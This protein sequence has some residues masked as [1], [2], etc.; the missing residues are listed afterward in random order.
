MAAR[1]SARRHLPRR[2]LRAPRAAPHL[3]RLRRPSRL[4]RAGARRARRARLAI[5]A[6]DVR[7]DAEAHPHELDRTLGR[8]RSR[9]PQ[10]RAARARAR[11]RVARRPRAS[12]TARSRAASS[13]RRRG[14]GAPRTRRATTSRR[15]SAP[16][17]RVRADDVGD[18]VTYVV[19]RNIN[20]TNV[21]FV[22]CHFCA[23][24]RQRWEEDAYT[25]GMD[26]VLGKVEEA[27]AR[28]ATEVCM[29]G[30]INPDMA[31]FTYRDVLVGHQDALPRDP[32]P[33]LL[34]DGDH[35]RRAADEHGLPGL[36]RHAARRRA[37]AASPARP[38]RSSTTR[39]ARSSR[40]RRSTCAP[41]SRSSP[42]RTA[43]ASRRRRRSCTATSR[44]AGHVARHI[45][46]IRRPPEGDAAA[47]PSSCRSAS[48]GRT[49][50]STTTARSTPQPK[51]L[52]DLRI[53]A[54]EPAHAARLDRQP[55]DLVGEARA[56]PVAALAARRLQRL[57]RHAD[58]GEHLARG[59][60]PTPGEYTSVEEIEA[61]VRA[62]G[63]RPVQR[64]TLYGRVG[65]GRCG[66]RGSRCWRV[67]WAGARFLR[68]LSRLT[69]PRRLTVIGNTGRR[70]G[71]LR[72]P[73]LAR[74]RHG[75][76][77]A[78]RARRSARAAGASAATPS[79]ASATLGA[80]GAPTWF[81]LGD[82]DLATHLLRTA[83][84]R[85]G[86]PLSRVTAAPRP[87]ATASARASCR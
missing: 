44:R 7:A 50:A 14:R 1:R 61:L 47:S 80:L 53:Y 49:R 5:G 46:L 21:C 42:P 18:D 11:P 45:D 3:P 4:P 81:R 33:R 24:K 86:W 38:P 69:D 82:R 70:R 13:T 83:R 78:R 2:G 67:A 37:S 15:W 30:G 74:P 54:V 39:C 48:S 79:P 28:G 8:D 63:R 22:N 16:P 71:V 84:L 9:R 59:R 43:S 29:Q 72:A 34:A 62:M 26:V 40:T 56:S 36:H 60:A 20:F 31:P 55:A 35:V 32:R 64:T 23:F 58:G 27:I 87:R 57:R 77:H 68:G 85:A 19:N 51:G 76:L 73:R 65:D 66:A 6:R 52:R 12:S 75:A 41:G 17:T 25:H 10:R